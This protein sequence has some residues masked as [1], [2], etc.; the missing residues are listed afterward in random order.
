M[1][2]RTRIIELDGLRGLAC[3]SVMFAH[4]FG[5]VQHGS[6]FL[7]L[8]W[9]GVDVFFVLSGFLIGGILLDNRDSDTYFSTFYIRR[10]FRIFPIYYVTISIVL[11]L[12]PTTSGQVW[13]KT[14]MPTLPYFV[15]L[16]NTVMTFLA[17]EG[18]YWLFPTWTLCVE[19]QFYL[20]LP[21]IVYLTP[22]PYMR[23]VA[24]GF[25]LSAAILRF[26]FTMTVSNHLS[27][28]LAEHVLLVSRWDLLF[29][30]VLAADVF[31]SREIWKKLIDRDFR[32]LKAIVL[33]STAIFPVLVM[34]DKFTGLPA[35]D[36]LG[37]SAIGATFMGLILLIAGGAHEAG[38]FRSKT[39]RFF[40]Q[41][42]YCLYLVHQPIAGIMHGLIL[43]GYPDIGNLA[44]FAVT[45]AA[46]AVSVG[47]AYMSWVYFEQPLIRIG[48]RWNYG[49]HSSPPL[50]D[51]SR[52]WA[53]P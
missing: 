17:T 10:G 35:F 24:I 49:S 2:Y 13:P 39:L 18:Y 45:I 3:L 44:E 26:I 23:S 48:H 34:V 43:G 36:L 27:L 46:V 53:K 22:S 32:V 47:I 42:S 31:R 41:I 12:L 5:E 9:A 29:F 28:M 21:L 19:E 52:G 6:R 50:D 4:Y 33:S 8:G 37:C 40:G 30:G 11:L 51:G 20:I 38:R 16:Q 25:I 14:D 1:N 7:A 15:Y